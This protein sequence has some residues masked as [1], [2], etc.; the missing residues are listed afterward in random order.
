M[1][2]SDKVCLVVKKLIKTGLKG[3]QMTIKYKILI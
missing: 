2:F 3:H 1:I